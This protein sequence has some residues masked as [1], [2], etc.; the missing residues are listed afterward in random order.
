[1]IVQMDY[2]QDEA[3]DIDTVFPWGSQFSRVELSQDASHVAAGNI[4]NITAACKQTAMS[5]AM[6]WP[7]SCEAPVAHKSIYR[8]L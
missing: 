5:G 1:M 4:I 8:Y 2:T 6:R 3:D 7:W